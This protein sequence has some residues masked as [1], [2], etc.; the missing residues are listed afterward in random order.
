M[1]VVWRAA[2]RVWESVLDSSVV[3]LVVEDDPD[4]RA[5]IEETLHEGGFEVAFATSGEEAIALLTANLTD[6][7]AL[8]TDIGL[9]GS[10]GGWD[11]ARRAREVEPTFPV[12][13]MSGAHSADW[14]SKGVPDS[15]MLAKPFA[16]AQLVTAVSNLLNRGLSA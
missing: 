12:V 9:P 6:Y 13:Y 8:V 2:L 15:V 11:V 4:I 3:I 7:R 14:S 1:V 10:L 16:P 5:V